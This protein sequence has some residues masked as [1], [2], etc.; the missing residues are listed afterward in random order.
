MR[1]APLAAHGAFDL[2]VYGELARAPWWV[3]N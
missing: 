1:S 2:V 3:W